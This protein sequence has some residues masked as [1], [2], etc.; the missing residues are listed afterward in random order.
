M[1]FNF[2][3]QFGCENLSQYDVGLNVPSS[4]LEY[5]VFHANGQPLSKEVLR[6]PENIRSRQVLV[7]ELSRK[8]PRCYL[9]LYLISLTNQAYCIVTQYYYPKT[10]AEMHSFVMSTS[11]PLI[12]NTFSVLAFMSGCK[13]RAVVLWTPKWHLMVCGIFQHQSIFSY[14]KSIRFLIFNGKKCFSFLCSIL[15]D[16]E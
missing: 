9:L 7:R 6:C 2:W 8:D 3:Q 14:K 13:F 4:Q 10:L 5:T 15:V 11:P 16:L 1:H 12:W